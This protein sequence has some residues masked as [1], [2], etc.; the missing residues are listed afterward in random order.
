MLTWALIVIIQGKPQLAFMYR[1]EQECR[2]A[3]PA[4]VAFHH[5]EDNQV[6]TGCYVL[7]ATPPR[8]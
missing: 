3:E 4:V 1:T 5:S 2:R 7:T 8:S 6:R